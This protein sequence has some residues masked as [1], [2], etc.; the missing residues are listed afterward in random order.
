[1]RAEAKETIKKFSSSTDLG[2]SDAQQILHLA[3][4]TTGSQ[5]LVGPNSRSQTRA[6]CCIST[7]EL[8]P[9]TVAHLSH[10]QQCSNPSVKHFAL[11]FHPVSPSA[12]YFSHSLP[13][14]VSFAMCQR[15]WT[16][17]KLWDRQSGSCD[18]H[19]QWRMY[20]KWDTIPIYIPHLEPSTA[21]ND[22]KS[23]LFTIIYQAVEYDCCYTNQCVDTYV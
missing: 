19:L 20:R 13:F 4:T 14:L 22:I 7:P 12:E 18:S 10:R 5:G 2:F 15:L 9:L 17:T 6:P 21:T 23:H 8:H 11:R 16:V 1:M 3:E